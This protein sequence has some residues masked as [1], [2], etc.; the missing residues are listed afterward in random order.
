MKKIIIVYKAPSNSEL[1]RNYLEQNQYRNGLIYKTTFLDF[2]E[3]FSQETYLEITQKISDPYTRSIYSK[4]GKLYFDFTKLKVDISFEDSYAEN[5]KKL[6]NRLIN[7]HYNNDG[8]FITAPDYYLDTNFKIGYVLKYPDHLLPD[9]KLVKLF[10]TLLDKEERLLQQ[11]KEKIA[12]IENAV[13][14]YRVKL[15][16]K[17]PFGADTDV[18]EMTENEQFITPDGDI[19]YNKTDDLEETYYI[20][21]T[22]VKLRSVLNEDQWQ[23]L[24][25]N[26]SFQNGP[27]L[28][29]NKSIILDFTKIQSDIKY[30]NILKTSDDLKYDKGLKTIFPIIINDPMEYVELYYEEG[31]QLN[32]IEIDFSV[33]E[34]AS[35]FMTFFIKMKKYDSIKNLSTAY[36]TKDARLKAAEKLHELNVR[37]K[38][39]FNLKLN[40]YF[41]NYII[42]F[43]ITVILLIIFL[44]ILNSVFNFI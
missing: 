13:N 19:F 1:M 36:E 3:D 9:V 11:K 29:K 18:S 17:T 22:E 42:P 4:K 14:T 34:L 27:I 37:K 16:Y 21:E 15:I 35:L 31:Y 28:Y 10:L 32:R 8:L 6:L 12:S 5:G 43:S 23:Y 24:V 40:Y 20:K 44:F 41:T 26:C 25:D 2:E 39:E 7:T 33:E 30:I 38:N